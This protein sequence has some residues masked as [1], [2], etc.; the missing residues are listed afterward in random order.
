MLRVWPW[1]KRQQK[2]K[3]TDYLLFNSLV[4]FSLFLFVCAF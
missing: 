4:Y 2:E 1:K 3:E